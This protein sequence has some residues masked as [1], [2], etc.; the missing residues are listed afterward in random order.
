MDYNS[1]VIQ[2]FTFGNVQIMIHDGNNLVNTFLLR[3]GE[4]K[5]FK[6]PK[7]HTITMNQVDVNPK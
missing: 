1:V 7:S 4:E 5:L 6:L 3:N 2:A